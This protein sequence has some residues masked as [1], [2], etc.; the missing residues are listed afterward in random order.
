MKTSRRVEERS[1]GRRSWLVG[2]QT[3]LVLAFLIALIR[4]NRE[5]LLNRL[6]T[7]NKRYTNPRVL[8]FA[9]RRK[10]PYAVLRHVGR[11]SGNTYTTPVVADFVP[12]L[13]SF[14]IP[15]PYGEGT[16]WCRNVMG[17]GRCTLTK[18]K[19]A[20]TLV[21][22]TIIEASDVLT[23]L[24]VQIQGTLRFLGLKKFLQLHIETSI[25]SDKPVDLVSTLER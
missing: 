7:F 9:A 8:Q 5:R 22:P 14:V 17:A 11:R 15:L 10:S 23:D 3:I 4:S 25:P 2:I 20:Y 19:V 16:D 6:R 12:R 13:N 18:N 1:T 21:E 24:P